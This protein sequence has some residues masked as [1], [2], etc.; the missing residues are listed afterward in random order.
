MYEGEKSLKNTDLYN[1]AQA[2]SV[3]GKS[4]KWRD[5]DEPKWKY[6]FNRYRYH[7]VSIIWVK[8]LLHTHQ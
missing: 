7:S 5:S 1:Y 2:L 8:T 4:K 3:G 6:S